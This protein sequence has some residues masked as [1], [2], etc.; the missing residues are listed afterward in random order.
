M[1]YTPQGGSSVPGATIVRKFPFAYNTAGLS[2]PVGFTPATVPAD[3]APT[4]P[5]TIV[6]ATNDTFV[7]TGGGG[8]GS[9]ETFTIAP[10]VYT[11]LAALAVA[12]AAATGSVSGEAFSTLVTVTHPSTVLVFTMAGTAGGHDNG[13]T[14]TEGDGGAA[15]IGI[16]SPPDTFAGGANGTIPGAALYTPTIGDILLNAW[17]EIDTAWDGTTPLG[18]FG[19]FTGGNPQGFL[20]WGAAG[21]VNM[22]SADHLGV[23]DDGMAGDLLGQH[24]T[25]SHLASDMLTNYLSSFAAVGSGA[26]NARAVPAK[27]VAAHPIRVCV[28]QDGTNTGA[29]P[30][31]TQ[32]AATLYLVTATPA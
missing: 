21:P 26:P 32:G 28:S 30:G 22:L 2:V 25:A 20:A 12:V 27:F 24:G 10:G 31:S 8:G 6:G 19:T 14:L 1:G 9:P 3:T 29:D 16:T 7:F 18:D 17:I 4:L 13:N 15:A 23:W 11:T 5:L